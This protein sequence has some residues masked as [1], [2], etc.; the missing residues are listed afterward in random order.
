MV[1]PLIEK[2]QGGIKIYKNLTIRGGAELRRYRR[3]LTDKENF[4]GNRSC[5]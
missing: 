5:R 3:F 4:K 2:F 1:M